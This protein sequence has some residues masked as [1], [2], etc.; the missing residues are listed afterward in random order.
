MSSSHS[1]GVVE[2]ERLRAR[3]VSEIEGLSSKISSMEKPISIDATSTTKSILTSHSPTR[4][5]L[6]ERTRS[7]SPPRRLDRTPD[8]VR[9]ASP[10]S[11][12]NKLALMEQS[13]VY[14]TAIRRA[15]ERIR[16]LEE[17]TQLSVSR[18]QDEACPNGGAKIFEL[19]LKTAKEAAHDADVVQR[20]HSPY[21][22]GA[23]RSRRKGRS[24]RDFLQK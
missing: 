10:S 18:S 15:H 4:T 1:N 11:S 22:A 8:R 20:E 23:P 17:E 12:T 24:Q 13:N 6:K 3:L 19:K 14:R 9:A 21:R 5:P 2:V 7:R 16:E